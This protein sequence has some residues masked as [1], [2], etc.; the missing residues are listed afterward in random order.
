MGSY[1]TRRILFALLTLFF[2]T[3]IV[4]FAAVRISESRLETL[5]ENIDMVEGFD[6]IET[7]S[8]LLGLDQPFYIH[9]W[10][11]VTA[12]LKGDFGQ[13]LWTSRY[14]ADEIAK[15]FPVTFELVLLLV[16][17]AHLITVPLAFLASWRRNKAALI[18]SKI[19]E[20][21]FNA[22][23]V[24]W[25]LI[26]IW[27]LPFLWTPTQRYTGFSEDWLAN[28]GQFII[29]A[30]ILGLYISGILLRV[31]RE[32]LSDTMTMDYIRTAHAKGLW[33]KDVFMR[34][35][36]RIVLG[37]MLKK[38]AAALPVIL[39]LMIFVESESILPGISRFFLDAIGQRDFP[40]IA[41]TLFILAGFC[42]AVFLF[43]DIVCAWLDPRIRSE[44]LQEKFEYL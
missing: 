10:N 40:T 43:T 36:L 24:F 3:I 30:V 25:L 27:L 16:I 33:Q 19:F 12:M 28:M 38:L 41:G 15:R 23:P 44:S 2:I 32:I 18:V 4:F 9:Y 22:V 35:G 17:F 1:I 20:S 6:C 34:H 13:S 21:V 8:H 39:G 7:F 37:K 26:L 5:C 31:Y 11:W 14:L 29:P 42:L